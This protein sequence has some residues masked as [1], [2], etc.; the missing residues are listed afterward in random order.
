MR[1]S[2]ILTTTLFLF[3][4]SSARLVGIAAPETIAPGSTFNVVIESVDYIQSVYDVSIAFGIA[5][6]KGYPGSMGTVLS[7]GYLGPSQSNTQDNITYSIT[8]PATTPKGKSLLSAG[9]F[10]L[11][12]AVGDPTITSFNVS[13]TVGDV[14]SESLVSSGHFSSVNA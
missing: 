10:S 12:G 14:T 4:L 7:S 5:A 3:T 1:T 8:L 11:Y 9:L 2:T 6:G 13:V